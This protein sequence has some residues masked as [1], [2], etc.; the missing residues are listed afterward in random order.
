LRLFAAAALLATCACAPGFTP[1]TAE[2][3]LRNGR[4]Y[5]LAWDDPDRNG[6]A[7]PAAP[8]DADGWHPDATAVA[9]E[10]GTILYVGD[11]AG[12]ERYVGADT[13]VV[14][15]DGATVLPGL[16]DAHTHVL[17]LG[18]T[19]EQVDL[20]DA[21]NEEE[22]VARVAGRAREAAAGTWIVGYGWDDGAWADDYPDKQLLSQAVPDHP[23]LM[24]GLHGFAVWG[25]QAALDRAGISANTAAPS[26]GR[27][28]LDA[29]GEP[30]GLFLDR[31]TELL[32][33]AVPAPTIEQ[34]EARYV[35]GFD[36]MARSGFTMVHEAGVDTMALRALQNL[37]ASGRLPLRV[38]AMLDA[39]DEELLRRWMQWGPDTDGNDL[40]MVRAVKAYYDGALGSRGARL[41]E[42]YS[43]QLDHY[44]VSGAEYGFDEE[45]VAEM[46]AAGFQANVH[47]I[48]DAG[49]RET[50]DFYERLLQRYPAANDLRHRVE[51]AQVVQAGDFWRFRTLGLTA[52]MQPPHAMEDKDWAIDRLGEE[53]LRGAYAWR[54]FRRIRVPLVFSSD[55]P[56]SDH[57][58]FYAWQAAITRRDKQLQPSGGWF[59]QQRMTAEEAVRGYT[60]WAARA[61]LIEDVSGK[62]DIGLWADMT[63]INIDPLAV[64]SA[65][66]DR[67]AQGQILMTIVDGRIIH[68]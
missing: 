41:L 6:V 61:A 55:L 13:R 29:A 51:H 40:L 30:T 10:R 11:D 4:V 50:L 52:S 59:P 21:A 35:L 36:E 24:R 60:S 17:N 16:V 42:P 7:A 44:G 23:V 57:D 12:V 31:A 27:I 38:Y 25:N 58:I 56:G 67:L 45:L 47:A 3:V 14:D 37:A 33:A 22:A 46:V 68:E 19:L 43:D 2:L 54:S 48:G 9:V 15:L 34:I 64:G 65:D 18:T 49:N 8:H 39:R 32:T 53:R 28:E 63:V 26:G 1:P 20:V 62:L 5:T 66:P